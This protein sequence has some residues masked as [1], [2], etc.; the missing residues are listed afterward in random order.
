MKKTLV[1]LTIA[2]SS[3]ISQ[4]HKCPN[5]E[6]KLKAGFHL[7]NASKLIGSNKQTEAKIGHAMYN[8]VV[9]NYFSCCPDHI[10]PHTEECLNA[11]FIYLNLESYERA[12][13]K[14]K[15]KKA[16]EEKED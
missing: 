8:Y 5:D 15:I 1:A 6:E 12:S 10:S 3:C 2:L 7:Y 13:I 4:G 16:S 14:E 11:S 9:K